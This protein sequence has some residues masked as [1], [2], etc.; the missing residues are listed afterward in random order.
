[1]VIMIGSAVTQKEKKKHPSLVCV[2]YWPC[3][4]HREDDL[5]QTTDDD[6][7]WGDDDGDRDGAPMSGRKTKGP[8]PVRAELS[9]RTGTTSLSPFFKFLLSVKG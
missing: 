1:M 4:W 6:D 2:F 3:A 5:D 8:P 9:A 7:D